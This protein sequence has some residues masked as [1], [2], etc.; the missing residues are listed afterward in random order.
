MQNTM[1]VFSSSLAKSVFTYMFLL[2]P[3]YMEKGFDTWPSMH[4][5]YNSFKTPT[6]WNFGYLSLITQRDNQ[7]Q[8][9][10][11]YC[12][13]AFLLCQKKIN[14]TGSKHLEKDL[15]IGFWGSSLNHFKN[16]ILS[17]LGLTHKLLIL[18]YFW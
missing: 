14:K 17:F 13:I 11:I 3:F 4:S 16:R 6:P 10:N 1:A 5:N 9:N 15:M 8:E 18:L 7:V 2:A 12:K